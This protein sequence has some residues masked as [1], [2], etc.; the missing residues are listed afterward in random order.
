[1]VGAA[2]RCHVEREMC[3]AS[4]AGALSTTSIGISAASTATTAT[5]LSAVRC[6]VTTSRRGLVIHAHPRLK[7]A[8][9]KVEPR[10]RAFNQSHVPRLCA[11][12]SATRFPRASGRLRRLRDTRERVLG[13]A[14]RASRRAGARATV[15]ASARAPVASAT[16]LAPRPRGQHGRGRRRAA[17]RRQ[18]RHA[19]RQF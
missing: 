3:G 11:G 4:Y 12:S 7:H 9:R 1:M 2:G 6:A 13:R 14:R 10:V 16:R 18:C 17:A 5:R 15:T 8:T 19:A